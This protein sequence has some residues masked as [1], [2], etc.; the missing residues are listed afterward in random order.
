MDDKEEKEEQ[1]PVIMIRDRRSHRTT[2]LNS[3]DIMSILRKRG[4]KEDWDKNPTGSIE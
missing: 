4:A 2:E 3:T 1:T